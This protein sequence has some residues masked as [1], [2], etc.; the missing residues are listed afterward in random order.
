MS[1]RLKRDEF[2]PIGESLEYGQ[3]TRVCHSSNDCMGSSKSM[4]IERQDNGDISAFC[5]RCGNRGFH[6]VNH[7]YAKSIK[8]ATR[9]F[10]GVDKAIQRRVEFTGIQAEGV[11][12]IERYSPAARI[13]ISTYGLTDKEIEDAGI[14]YSPDLRRIVF[15]WFCDSEVAGYQ[16]RRIYE[17]DKGPKYDTH[18]FNPCSYALRNRND[19]TTCCIVE[20]IIS[21]IKCARYVDT[22]VLM[23]TNLTSEHKKFLLHSKY[24]NHIIFLDDD[25]LMVKQNALKIKRFIDKFSDSVIIQSDGKDPKEHTDLELQEIFKCNTN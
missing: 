9:A 24:N 19:G 8:R 22:L 17:D 3:K 2:V 25:N 7:R 1:S 20:D 13:W 5:F 21:G 12:D 4:I 14:F 6:S 11:R 18:V 15:P 23:S 10:D 16:T